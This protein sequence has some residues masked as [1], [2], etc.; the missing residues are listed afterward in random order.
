MPPEIDLPVEPEPRHSNW[1]Q[2]IFD[3]G[4]KSV[5]LAASLVLLTVTITEYFIRRISYLTASG[6]VQIEINES[7]SLVWRSPESN[8]EGVFYLPA[9]SAWTNSSIIVE[10]GEK[11]TIEAAGRACF[12]VDQLVRSVGTRKKTP[13]PWVGP[14]GMNL[15]VSNFEDVRTMLENDDLGMDDLIV[16]SANLGTLL[17]YPRSDQDSIPSMKNNPR[18]KGVKIVGEYLVY[19]NNR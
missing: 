4:W 17:C 2:T 16:P 12:A 7:G 19:R 8:R 18:P 14:E 13:F 9:S 3:G 5:A 15:E 1:I 6:R 11:I 10:P